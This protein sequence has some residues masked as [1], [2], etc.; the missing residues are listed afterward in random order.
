LQKFLPV[1]P[2][3]TFLQLLDEVFEQITLPFWDLASDGD[4]ELWE[5]HAR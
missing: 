4:N 3:L 2:E 5:T 1:E